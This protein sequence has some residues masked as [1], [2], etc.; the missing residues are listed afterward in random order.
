MKIS[1][2]L[3]EMKPQIVYLKD[4]Y[5]NFSMLTRIKLKKQA[6]REAETTGAIWTFP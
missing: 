6:E 5:T 3:T 4:R 1:L 2:S